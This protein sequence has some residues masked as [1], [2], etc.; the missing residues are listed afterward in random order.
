MELR[1]TL[2]A[3]YANVAE[4]GKLNVMGVFSE[5]YAVKFP[6]RH[7]EMTLILQFSVSPAEIG[8][9]RKLVVK[10]V[11]EDGKEGILEYTRDV[12]I[13]AF[14]GHTVRPQINHILRFRDVIFPHAG[15]YVFYIQV[16]KDDKGTCAIV[17]TQQSEKGK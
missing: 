2:L 7:P 16:D 11:D 17:I 9:M 12:V 8:Q 1:T 4:G 15:V 14:P 6:A 13:P 10:L 5:I 3:D